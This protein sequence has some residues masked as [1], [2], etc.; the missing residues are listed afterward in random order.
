[1]VHRAQQ[2]LSCHKKGGYWWNLVVIEAKERFSTSKTRSKSDFRASAW[3]SEALEYLWPCFSRR[4][5]HFGLKIL[6]TLAINLTP[7]CG[8]W[9]NMGPDLKG[10]PCILMP[11]RRET[12]L[13]FRN[14]ALFGNCK[15]MSIAA[16]FLLV[17]LTRAKTTRGTATTPC[18][19]SKKVYSFA[20]QCLC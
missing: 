17:S 2:W 7:E 19:S 5:S 1:M 12:Y 10:M 14:T 4:R 9:R 11:G 6:Y 13:K 3:K 18:P 16:L 15:S 20:K 8:V